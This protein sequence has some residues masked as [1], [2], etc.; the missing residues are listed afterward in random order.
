MK[1][2]RYRLLIAAVA[3]LLGSAIAKSQTAE[4]APP[5]P[6]P[7]HGHEFGMEGEGRMMGFFAHSLNLTDEQKSQMK[8]ILQKEHPTI[9]PLVQQQRQIDGQLRQYVEGT[10]DEVKVRALAVQKSQVETE[11]TVAHTR[12]HNELYQV[13]TADQRTQLKEMEAKHEARMQQHMHDA[14]PPPAEE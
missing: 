5:P 11:L 14:P 13:L 2:I 10:Y 4:D 12:V 1:S 8:S 3:V 6:P 9:K 7:M